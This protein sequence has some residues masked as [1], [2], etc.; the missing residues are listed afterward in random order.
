MTVGLDRQVSDAMEA[1]RRG[2]VAG[3]REYARA[4][5]ASEQVLLGFELFNRQ[6]VD[7]LVAFLPEEFVHDMRPTGTPGMGIFTGPEEYRR[8]LEDW[9]GVFPSA[10]LTTSSI[11]EAGGTVLAILQQRVAGSTSGVPVEFAYAA[12]VT[13]SDG[14]PVRSEFHI[15]LEAAR[16]RFRALTT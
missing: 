3:A 7:V 6:A 10:Q 14:A 16:A 1:W 4:L 15:D 12:I 5:S 2:G 8:F 11:E 13:F 9:L